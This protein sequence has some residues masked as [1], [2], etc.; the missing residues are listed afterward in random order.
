MSKIIIK[1][2][3]KRKEQF[4]SIYRSTEILETSKWT[5]DKEV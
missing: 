4:I 5:I 2:D 3:R 1:L